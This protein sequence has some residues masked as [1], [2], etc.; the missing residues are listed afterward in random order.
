MMKLILVV[1]AIMLHVVASQPLKIKVN[2]MELSSNHFDSRKPNKSKPLLLDVF[3]SARTNPKEILVPVLKV[4]AGSFKDEEKSIDYSEE[5]NGNTHLDDRS[6]ENN[7][8]GESQQAYNGTKNES[9]LIKNKESKSINYSEEEGKTNSVDSSLQVEESIETNEKLHSHATTEKSTVNFGPPGDFQ[10]PQW[11][12]IWKPPK[13]PY[14]RPP[15]HI[16]YPRPAPWGHH[17]LGPHGPHLRRNN[18]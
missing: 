1:A 15:P 13:I 16:P 6:H 14:P 12:P 11:P 8:A 3:Q 17:L 2:A 10:G 7:E 5:E 18:Q 4:R 9:R